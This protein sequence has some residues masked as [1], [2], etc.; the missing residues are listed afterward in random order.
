MSHNLV[1]NTC[2]CVVWKEVL[3]THSGVNTTWHLHFSLVFLDCTFALSDATLNH[4]LLGL[5]F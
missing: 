4:S 2:I 1:S 3:E 5:V